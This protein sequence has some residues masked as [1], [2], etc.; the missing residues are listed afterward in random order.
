MR[1]SVP[2]CPS[3]TRS[4]TYDAR[5]VFSSLLLLCALCALSSSSHAADRTDV[6]L[7]NWSGF[8]IHWNW[9][10]DAIKKLVLAGLTDRAVL[11]T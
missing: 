1:L 6:P 7:R 9:A 8:A 10:Y 4:R 3:H 2:A 11:N 5:S